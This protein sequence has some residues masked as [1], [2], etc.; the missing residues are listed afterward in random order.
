MIIGA[1]SKT[2]KELSEL[3]LEGSNKKL[4]EHPIQLQ[5]LEEILLQVQAFKQYANQVNQP[6]IASIYERVE[7][8]IRPIYTEKQKS[9]AD[10]GKRDFVFHMLQSSLKYFQN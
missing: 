1:N 10:S 3:W 4:G 9:L 7:D 8:L 6:E 5:I 2:V